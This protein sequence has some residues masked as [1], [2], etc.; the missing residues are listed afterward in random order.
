[1]DGSGGFASLHNKDEEDDEEEEADEEEEEEEEERVLCFKKHS[2]VLCTASYDPNLNA[3]TRYIATYRLGNMAQGRSV[4]TVTTRL[5]ITL[6]E[7]RYV[8]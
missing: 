6:S 3:R 5:R 2:S 1:L 7:L 4:K 8:W